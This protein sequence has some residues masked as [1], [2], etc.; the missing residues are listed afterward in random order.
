MSVCCMEVKSLLDRRFQ[1]LVLLV[2]R[3][4]VNL[5]DSLSRAVACLTPCHRE[6]LD[7]KIES[8]GGSKFS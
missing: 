4:A 3:V 2:I 1:N 5:Y 6:F 8:L 7:L